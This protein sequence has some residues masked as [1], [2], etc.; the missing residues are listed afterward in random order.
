MESVSKKQTSVTV[1]IKSDQNF[2][3][4]AVVEGLKA[5][6][7]QNIETHPSF[8]MVSGDVEVAKLQE[9]WRVEGVASVRDGQI[10]K[11][12]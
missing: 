8:S 11:P 2:R 7:L 6:G 9:L 4:E 10:Y 5:A 12:Q 1:R 3:I